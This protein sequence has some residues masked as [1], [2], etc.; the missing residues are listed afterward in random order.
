MVVVTAGAEARSGDPDLFARADVLQRIP[1]RQQRLLFRRSHIG[2]DETVALLHRI[3]GLGDAIA[4]ARSVVGL[5]GLIEAAA[6]Y[7]EQPA[8]IAA[9][10]AFVFDL[11]VIERGAAMGAARMQQ[12]GAALAVAEDDEVFA[13]HAQFLRHV[14]NLFRQC[15]GVPVTAHEFAERRACAHFR[16]RGIVGRWLAAVACGAPCRL[17]I[18]RCC[19]H[20]RSP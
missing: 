18:D 15:D 2:P 19:A 16:D 20:P 5:A 3:P 1:I 11:A 9:A 13:E 10:D 14:L 4:A 8:M 12:A 17:G 7:V 6:F